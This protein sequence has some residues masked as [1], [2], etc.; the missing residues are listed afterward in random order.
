MSRMDRYKNIHKKAK[1]LKDDSSSIFRRERKKEKYV[2]QDDATRIYQNHQESSNRFDE[3]E[4]AHQRQSTPYTYQK[5][6]EQEESTFKKKGFFHRNKGIKPPK[7]RKK[8]S[9][10]RIVLGIIFF[11]LIYSI[12]SFFVGKFVAEH[13]KSLES[14]TTETFNGIQSSSGAHNILILGSDTRGEDAG[15]QIRS[16]SYN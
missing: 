15:R 12:G 13:D 14:A 3:K 11:L 4:A 2:E 16:W 5:A 1:P 8:H 9:W 6:T 10:K 7:Q